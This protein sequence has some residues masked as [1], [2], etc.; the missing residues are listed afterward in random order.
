[1]PEI[2]INT[3]I[4]PMVM[5]MRLQGV[6]KEYIKNI[7]LPRG[8]NLLYLKS[9]KDKEEIKLLK[10]YANNDDFTDQDFEKLFK[11]FLTSTPRLEISTVK[12]N[13]SNNFINNFGIELITVDEELEFKLIDELIPN[14]KVDTWECI[15]LDLLKKLYTEEINKY[16]FDNIN[17]CLGA[18]KTETDEVN[19]SLLGALRSALM[20]TLVG[21]LYGDDKHLYNS[22][23]KYFEKE[24]SKRVSLINGLWK[25]RKGK[26]KY[27]PIFDSFYN[28]DGYNA[29]NLIQIIH[30]I[31]DNTEIITDDKAMIRNTLIDSAT[32][33][34]NNINAT[35]EK[36]E[37]SVV[38]PVVNYL[39]EIQNSEND[40]KAAEVLY[41]QQLYNQ[42][43]NRS[44][45]CMMHAL[46]A[47]LEKEQMLSDWVP[48]RL[49]V[50]ENHKQLEQKFSE[51]VNSRKVSRSYFSDFRY[52][53][54]QRWIADYNIAI[55]DKAICKECLDKA[56]DFFAEIKKITL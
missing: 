23:Y 14:I 19:Q 41:N 27:I 15:A 17:I 56:K 33:F 11:L 28:L 37:K 44:Y 6:N 46:K 47:M 10:K 8:A 4:F 16:D 25:T 43:A 5:S 29:S 55:I 12:P 53:K 35:A 3:S 45:Y 48:N 9:L 52:V 30:E 38:K 39:V 13:E 22:F 50:Q 31:L 32:T 42:S 18:W 54:Q 40:L 24:F 34:H 51:L 7:D 49:N 36:I 2:K 1:M 21:F 20:F 26:I